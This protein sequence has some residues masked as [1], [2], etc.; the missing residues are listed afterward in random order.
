[1]SLKESKKRYLR[2]FETKKGEG[3]NDVIILYV[4][5][6]KKKLQKGKP[7]R[8]ISASTLA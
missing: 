8:Q 3:R 7:G 2:G 1:M 6:Y 4:Q 5:K